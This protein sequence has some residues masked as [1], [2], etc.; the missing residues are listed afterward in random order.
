VIDVHGSGD[1]QLSDLTLNRGYSS[2]GRDGS[3][4]SCV[5]GRVS[6]SNVVI[7]DCEAVASAA[8]VWLL[9]ATASLTDV[10]I[11]DNTASLCGGLSVAGAS[12]VTVERTNIVGNTALD[13]AGG[14]ACHWSGEAEL[15]DSTIMANVVQ[16]G[17]HGG[18]LLAQAGSITLRGCRIT[19]GND[20]GGAIHV[21]A[22]ASLTAIDTS[23]D[24]QATSDGGAVLVSGGSALFSGCTLVGSAGR[25]GG[26]VCV[27]DSGVVE[28]VNS[29]LRG[30][31]LQ[32]GALSVRDSTVLLKSCTLDGAGRAPVLS[33]D[34]VHVSGASEVQAGHTVFQGP[35][36]ACVGELVSLGHDYL[37]N[38]STC[39][40]SGDLNGNIVG[41]GSGLTPLGD[42]G[43]PTET[44]VPAPG[45][46]LIDAG[47]PAGCTDA[48]GVLL[49]VDQR[50]LPR[51]ADGDGD[52]TARC[53]IG[54]VEAC[55][56]DSDLDG[57][58]DACDCAPADPQAF[59]RP[60]QAVLHVGRIGPSEASLTWND[61]AAGSGPGVLYD[62]ASDLLSTLRMTRV[63][64]APCLERDLVD[65]LARDARTVEDDGFYYLVRGNNVCVAAGEGWGS[66][67]LDRARG[68]CP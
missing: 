18:G 28:A 20:A 16:L 31:A 17:G 10:E 52:G 44:M 63:V 67:G 37:S 22:D 27:E 2:G 25:L 55:G 35:F 34:A 6:L 68:A 13:G 56:T 23:V 58:G 65:T 11:R 21:A 41:A 3:G 8:A 60:G 9:D 38:N 59:A 66:D 48:S 51:L 15:I 12:V 30:S 50:G 26:A 43:G 14:G 32:G 29:T 57:R 7:R 61:L 19:G 39:T 54:A 5:G 33:G 36:D 62:V 42:N 64:T 40:V 45:S 53:D 46:P 1:L 24:G 47:N 49:V 4:L